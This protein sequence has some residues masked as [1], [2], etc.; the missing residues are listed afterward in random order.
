MMFY[1]SSEEKTSHND[2]VFALENISNPK[3]WFNNNDE[4][5]SNFDNL[6]GPENSKSKLHTG[7]VSEQLLT[8]WLS[9]HIPGLR[10]PSQCVLE[11][12]DSLYPLLS[13]MKPLSVI[14]ISDMCSNQYSNCKHIGCARIYMLSKRRVTGILDN[15]RLKLLKET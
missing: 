7:K 1:T 9:S 6:S 5:K 13:S 3:I 15:L 12:H 11:S 10:Q 8:D 14:S 2:N 4:E